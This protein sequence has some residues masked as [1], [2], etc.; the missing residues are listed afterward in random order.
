MCN[1]CDAMLKTLK[2]LLEDLNSTICGDTVEIIQHTIA[3]CDEGENPTTLLGDKLLAHGLVCDDDYQ[4]GS[5]VEPESHE[6][7]LI[8]NGEEVF[9]NFT[10]VNGD[11]AVMTPIPDDALNFA[12]KRYPDVHP[13]DIKSDCQKCS[14]ELSEGCTFAFDLL[15]LYTEDG[16]ILNSGPLCLK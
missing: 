10:D 3:Q 2:F 9:R 12:K 11:V 15:G 13:C 8:I 7:S 1:S 5:K 14:P 6:I 4:L 16:K